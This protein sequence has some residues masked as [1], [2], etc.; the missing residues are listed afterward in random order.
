MA[1]Q[2]K[3][4]PSSKDAVERASK[5]VTELRETIG[6]P[7]DSVAKEISAK[8]AAL[9]KEKGVVVEWDVR[10][11]RPGGPVEALCNCHCYA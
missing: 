7:S 8:L 5:A 4:P 10:V 11:V 1:D 3:Y 9:A 2:G 6:L